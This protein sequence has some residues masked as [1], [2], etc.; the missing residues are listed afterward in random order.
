MQLHDSKE[1]IG[2]LKYTP[3]SG[4]GILAAGSN[5]L[6]IYLY[7]VWKGYE[8][9]ARCVGH[10]GTIEHLDWSLPIDS[11]C[12]LDGLTILQSNDTSRE[13]LHWDPR[14]GRQITKNQRDAA[15]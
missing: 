8:L 13:I 7:D 1:C 11:H 5:D 14:T 10:S 4:P 9:I 12:K 2:E 3:P 6:K 15:W